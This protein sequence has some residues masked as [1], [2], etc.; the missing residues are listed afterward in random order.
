MTRV[1]SALTHRRLGASLAAVAGAALISL[2]SARA[3]AQNF[4]GSA[5][6]SNGDTCFSLFSTN[7]STLV[8]AV[9]AFPGDYVQYRLTVNGVY[10]GQFDWNITKT[11]DPQVVKNGNQLAFLNVVKNAVYDVSIQGCWYPNFLSS[12]TCHTWAEVAAV[13][14]SDGSTAFTNAPLHPAADSNLCV[15]LPNSDT[16]NYNQL[17]L[18]GCNGTKAQQWSYQ[19]DGTI[20]SAIDYNKCVDLSGSNTANGTHIQIYDCN[21]TFAQKWSYNA[22]DASITGYYGHCIDVPSS[23]FSPGTKLQYYT[24]NGS[25]AQVWKR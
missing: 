6:N 24:C 14:A 11:G 18:Y 7:S 10:K 12:S 21:G 25:P 5:C 22:T 1:V 2:V 15:D 13:T 16:T 23:N 19:S 20:H 3:S 8:M 9:S 4:S 17:Q